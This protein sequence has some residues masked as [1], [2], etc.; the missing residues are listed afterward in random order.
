[1]AFATCYATAAERH[2]SLP[3]DGIV[4]NPI[5]TSTHAITIDA[6]PEQVWPWIAQMGA[7]RAGWYSWDLIDNGGM[8]SARCIVPELQTV[9]RG[10]VMP[11][12]P[13]ASDAFVVAAVDPPRDL[14]LTV[15]N[16]HG[17]HAVVWEHVLE[18]IDGGRTRLIVRGRASSHWLDLAR[19]PT[20]AGHHR[21]FIERAYAVLA[22]LPRP[23]LIAFAGIGHR[24]MEA[25]H[26][27]GI[28]R[29]STASAETSAKLERWRKPLLSGGILAAFLYVS[30]TLFVGLLWE[31]YSVV[32]RVPSELSA[33]GAPT[34]LLWTWLGAVY[35]VL[36][37]AFGWIVWKSAPPNRA[38]RVVGAL[39]MAH[40]V[41]GQFWPP[42]HQRAVLAAGGGTLTDTLHLVWA[43]VTGLFFMLM[44]GFGAAALGKRFRVYS[45]VTIVIVLACGAVTGTYASR[46]QADLPT[47]WVG[48]WERI[49]IAT[50]MG[51]IA[52]LATA[53]LRAP[54]Q[55]PF[56]ETRERTRR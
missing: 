41:F 34:R 1:M 27:R 20:P 40:T 38:L 52:V 17:A 56:G 54:N 46:V 29:R 42:M 47:P 24:M 37:I 11:A 45:I 21:I 28:Q 33:I 15:G 39:L 2:R 49:S 50:F 55:R 4:P 51:W 16:G 8:P 53:L 36:M 19:A 43:A 3:A 5:F 26:L 31:G 7:G 44:V 25:R 13:H 9:A 18:P 30:M 22:R 14:V 23:L 10:D 35:G 6:P 48:V 12:V 32:S